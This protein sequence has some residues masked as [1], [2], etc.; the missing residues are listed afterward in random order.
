M[1]YRNA[2]NN[3]MIYILWGLKSSEH[4]YNFKNPVNIIKKDE[5]WF[6]FHVLRKV[7]TLQDQIL[8]QGGGDERRSRWRWNEFVIR[9][10]DARQEED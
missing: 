9:V 7:K 3:I 6:I 5:K 2:K 8:S 4:V 10:R 1:I